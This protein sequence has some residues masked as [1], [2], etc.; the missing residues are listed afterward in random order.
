MISSFFAFSSIS[1]VFLIS[2]ASNFLDF[3]WETLISCSNNKFKDLDEF[4]F[5]VVTSISAVGLLKVSIS[6]ASEL[7]S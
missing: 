4:F 7:A 6:K 1:A 5:R 3:K 2:F